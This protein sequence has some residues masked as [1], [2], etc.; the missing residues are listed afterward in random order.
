MAAG[1]AK[2]SRASSR[3]TNQPNSTKLN[4]TNMQAICWKKH[5]SLP[6]LTLFSGMITPLPL[7]GYVL[8]ALCARQQGQLGL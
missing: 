3:M 2:D 4:Q 5:E 7:V 8:R 1:A 6:P